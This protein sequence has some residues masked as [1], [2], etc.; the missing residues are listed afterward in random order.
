[1]GQPWI[2]SGNRPEKEGQ[3]KVTVF[4]QKPTECRNAIEHILND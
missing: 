3:K 4:D 1:M 2:F